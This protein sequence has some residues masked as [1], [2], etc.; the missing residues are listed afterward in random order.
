MYTQ[1]KIKIVIRCHIMRRK[2][3]ETIVATGQI[4]NRKAEVDGEKLCWLF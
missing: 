2:A 3:L 4:S 1:I